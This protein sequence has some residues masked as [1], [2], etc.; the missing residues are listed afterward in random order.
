MILAPLLLALAAAQSSVA[1]PAT[2]TRE[3]AVRTTVTEI[4][5]RADHFMDRCVTVAGP[6][7]ATAM[8][9]DVDAIYL[10]Y[11][12]SVFG[13]AAGARGRI[14]LYSQENLLR[15]AHLSDREPMRLVVTGVV[16]SCQRMYQRVL[17]AQQ[18]T[19]AIPLPPPMMGGYCHWFGGPVVRVTSWEIDRSGH[20]E[21]LTGEDAR[22]RVGDLVLA[23]SRTPGYSVLQGFAREFADAVRRGDRAALARLHDFSG[24]RNP[25]DRQTLDYILNDAVSSFVE[26]RRGTG[27]DSAIF[28]RRNAS[29][30][31][32][33]GVSGV[34]C[35]CRSASCRDRWPISI[36]D[37]GND[38]ERPFACTI[39]EPRNWEPRGAGL[40]TG[41][42]SWLPEPQR[43]SAVPGRNGSTR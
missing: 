16:D 30:T 18:A 32:D 25:D 28:V 23:T 21:R 17:S 37:A 8:F 13:P 24:D 12:P 31:R 33:E 5:R 41:R 43:A 10:G 40:N 42:R 36:F 2:C 15:A 14:G 3:Q 29:I 19:S 27:G 1:P 11:Y 7:S 22:R 34:L 38:P 26:L 20:F 6:S 9:R 39:V 35:F 4:V